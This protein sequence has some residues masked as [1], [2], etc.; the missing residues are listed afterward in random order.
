MKSFSDFLS[1]LYRS[2]L[3]GIMIGIGGVVYLSADIK[4]VGALLFAIGLFVICTWGFNLY[5]GKI[6]YLVNNGLSYIK[7]LLVILLGNLAGTYL[8]GIL[9][10]STRLSGVVE[11]AVAVCATKL[12]D[13]L[14]SIFILA[15]FCGA[16]MYLGVEGYRTIADPLGKYLSVFLAVMVFILSGFEHC[17]A[18]MFYFSVAAVWS[19]RSAAFMLV[20]ILGN[21][22]GSLFFSFMKHLIYKRSE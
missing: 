14:P 10:R 4:P 6:G 8:A 17:V 3:A 12:A 15:F 19:L 1:V 2:I 5:T 20:M 13:G 11:N 7:E 21:S 18:N 22:A 9:I 16:L